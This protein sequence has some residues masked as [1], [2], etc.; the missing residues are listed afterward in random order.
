MTLAI[1]ILAQVILGQLSY[2]IVGKSRTANMDD[3]VWDACL[4]RG[5]R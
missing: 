3:L 5:S 4:L 2:A 1:V